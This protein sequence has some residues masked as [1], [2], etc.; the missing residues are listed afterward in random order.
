MH[1]YGDH[2]GMKTLIV[3]SMQDSSTMESGEKVI[4]EGM[5]L[6]HPLEIV[7]ANDI[8]KFYGINI[9]E[10]WPLVHAN[11]MG[12][13]VAYNGGMVLTGK[14]ANRNER[15]WKLIKDANGNEVKVE[16]VRRVPHNPEMDDGMYVQLEDLLYFA[17]TQGWTKGGGKPKSK[18]HL[19]T[20]SDLSVLSQQ[21]AELTKLMGA[22][23]TLSVEEKVAA[24]KA[25]K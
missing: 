12:N 23:V 4:I 9:R 22:F 18:E 8:A 3:T 7:H 24:K 25:A 15:F 19:Q 5:Q 20:T 21:I 16:R 1:T 2:E 6:E 11:A 13:R 10:V 17:E 14:N